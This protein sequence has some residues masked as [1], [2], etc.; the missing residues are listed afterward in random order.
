MNKR[1]NRKMFFTKKNPEL[2]KIKN[3]DQFGFWLGDPAN[4]PNAVDPNFSGINRTANVLQKAEA[5]RAGITRKNLNSAPRWIENSVDANFLVGIA[6]PCC[7]YSYDVAPPRIVKTWV[8][9]FDRSGACH[10]VGFS[11]YE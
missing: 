1:Q 4:N 8:K 11:M 9:S 2:L 6:C 7:N 3:R 5:R 10:T